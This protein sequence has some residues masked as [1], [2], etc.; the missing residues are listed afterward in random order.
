MTNPLATIL[1]LLVATLT[2]CS[3]APPMERQLTTTPHG[4]ILTNANVW[5]ADGQW[6]AYD[7]R[8]DAEGSLFDGARIERVNVATGEIQVLY[9]ARNN[10]KCGVVTCH[11]T[12]DKVVFILGPENPTKEWSYGPTHRQGVIVDCRNPGV[13]TNLDA[14]DLADPFTPGALRGG[15]HVHVFSPDGKWVSF[16]YNDDLVAKDQRNVGVSRLGH[17]V[18]VGAGHARNHDGSAFSVLL[19][20]TTANPRPGSDEIRRAFEDAWVMGTFTTKAEPGR[21]KGARAVAF[22]G[23]VIKAN[24]QPISEVF[25]VDL[26]PDPTRPSDRPLQGTTTD[27]PAPPSGSAQRRLTHT[28]DRKYPGL[29]GPRHWL[30]SS[31]DGTRIAFLMKDDAGVGQLWTISPEGGQPTQLTHNPHPIASAFTWSPDGRFIAYAM[32]ASICLTD[33]TTG[34]TRRLTPRDV[35]HPARPEACVFSPDGS[36]IA[37]VRTIDGFNQIFVT[38]L[39]NKERP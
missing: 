2:G 17:P 29:C 8:S 4:H 21:F 9:R 16:T 3:Q 7:V 37:Y 18:H 15:T 1:T 36:Q 19:T 26:P 24:G 13:A 22:Q 39:D 28:A 11:P 32:D 31:P 34:Q 25:I 33:T 6:I 23:E 27:L 10:A 30:R 38:P 5:S 35:E 12:E 14:R 20:R